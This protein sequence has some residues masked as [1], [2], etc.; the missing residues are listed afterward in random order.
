MEPKLIIWIIGVILYFWIK[1]RKASTT[2]NPEDNFPGPAKPSP[3]GPVTFED[4]LREIQSAKRSAHET[5]VAPSNSYKTYEDISDESFSESIPEYEYQKDSFSSSDTYKTY[6]KAKSEAFQRSSLEDTLK[7]EDTEVKYSKF[8]EYQILKES[9]MAEKI[10]AE[11]REPDT[12]KKY[13]VINE[14]L[15]RKWN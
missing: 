2:P 3:G 6:E 15:N 1:S 5:T 9:T 7:L 4:L 11:F 12:L 10:A 8:S 14:I 13:F